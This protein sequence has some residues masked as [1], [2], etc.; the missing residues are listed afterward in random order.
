MPKLK[1]EWKLKDSESCKG[2]PMKYA[3]P[4]C[5]T[6]TC[7]IY[8]DRWTEFDDWVRPQECIDELGE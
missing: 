5:D 1:K 3:N 7:I 4:N 2:C 6:F 8:G